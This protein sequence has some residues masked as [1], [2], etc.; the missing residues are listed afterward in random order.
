VLGKGIEGAPDHPDNLEEGQLVAYPVKIISK[1]HW[2]PTLRT[3]KWKDFQVW[4][5]IAATKA[6]GSPLSRE[7][8]SWHNYLDLEQTKLEAAE[9]PSIFKPKQLN[10]VELSLDTEWALETVPVGACQTPI[11][12]IQFDIP[13]GRPY[14]FLNTTLDNPRPIPVTST[15]LLIKKKLLKLH[16]EER[17]PDYLGPWRYPGVDCE[18]GI[19]GSQPT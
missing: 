13:V 16:I 14:R 2:F 7:A 15:G 4:S 18:R 11:N 5:W 17:L 3:I 6:I 8:I 9:F 19:S 1:P 10:K 12:T